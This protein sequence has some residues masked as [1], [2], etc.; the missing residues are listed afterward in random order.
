GPN[1][2]ALPVFGEEEGRRVVRG[3]SRRAVDLQLRHVTIEQHA[4]ICYATRGNSYV[5]RAN[6]RLNKCTVALE[7]PNNQVGRIREDG[8]LDLDEPRMRTWMR[9]L[10]SQDREELECPMRGYADP[11]PAAS[12][13]QSIRLQPAPGRADPL[14][15]PAKTA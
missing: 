14:P 9:G 7:H 10:W 4:P 15:A 6:G 2:G 13:P 11:V 3:L 5:V 8:F 12:Q 1:D